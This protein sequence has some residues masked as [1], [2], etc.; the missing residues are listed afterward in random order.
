MN[1]AKLYSLPKLKFGYGELAPYMSEEQLALHHDKHHLAYVNGANSI[2]EKIDKARKDDQTLDMKST[3]KEL[4]FHIG[5]HVLHTLFWENLSPPS[6]HSGTPTGKVS[7]I[8]SKEFGS[9]DRFK[10]EFSQVA[11]SVEGSGW[12]VLAFCKMTQRPLI[13]QIEKHNV[14]IYPGFKLLLVLD[15]WEHAYYIDYKNLRGKFVDAFWNIVN[16]SE[17]ERRLSEVL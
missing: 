2:L 6:S 9:F 15:L 10:N 8:I 12:A 7:E 4:S 16:W 3:L 17:V 14:N 1:N 13:M 5:G 11:N